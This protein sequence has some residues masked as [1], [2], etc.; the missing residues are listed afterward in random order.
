MRAVEAVIASQPFDGCRGRE[1]AIGR[2]RRLEARGDV[3]GVAPHVVGE[4]ARADNPCHHGP[5]MQADP[6]RKR[7]RQ[8]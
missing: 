7:D 5:G 3:D 8:P 2:T 1:R 6:D 4:L